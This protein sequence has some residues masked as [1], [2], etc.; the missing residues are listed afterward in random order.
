M[1]PL[2]Q[3][4]LPSSFLAHI[5]SYISR[6][7]ALLVYEQSQDRAP[8]FQSVTAGLQI[9]LLWSIWSVEENG[10]SNSQS[11]ADGTLGI[12]S[13]SPQRKIE[14]GIGSICEMGSRDLICAHTCTRWR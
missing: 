1:A 8:S 5:S 12:R 14:I 10:V 7:V 3:T 11:F 4:Q 9:V 2:T 13:A 6:P